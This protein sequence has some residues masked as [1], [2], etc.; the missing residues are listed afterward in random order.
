MKSPKRKI[1]EVPVELIDVSDEV[2]RISID[3]EKISE[4]AQSI[5]EVGLLQ[6]VLLRAVGERYEMIAGHRRWLAFKRLKLS[7]IDAVVRKM[8]DEEAAIV[9]ATENLSRENLSPLEEAV[10]FEN[11]TCKFGMGFEDIGKKF[12]YKPGTVRRRMDLLKMPEVLREAVH[13]KQIGVT[14]AEE[15]WPIANE[16]DLNYYLMFA[17]ES[18][19]TATTAR[20]WCKDWRDQKRRE[21][22]I[23]ERGGG[24]VGVNEPRPVYLP[25]DLCSGPTVLGSEIVMR[26]C[27]GC[28]ATIKANM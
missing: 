9:R 22:D 15:L 7:V 28:H 13:N 1:L 24:V 2:D 8:S 3:V 11:L 4:L 26:I 17:I 10:I 16:G 23:D 6:P 14:V 21:K 5:S 12:G 27:P 19:C 20:G 18:G 25:C